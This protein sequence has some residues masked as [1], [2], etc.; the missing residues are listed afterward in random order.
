M[1]VFLPPWANFT[2]DFAGPYVVKGEVKRRARMKILIFIY[3]CL[4]TGTGCLLAF[5]G[6]YTSDFLCQHA[7]VVYR[8]G[9]PLTMVSVKRAVSL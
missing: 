8:K 9:Q 6:F 5:P 4:A 7:G 2:L 3:C 1:T